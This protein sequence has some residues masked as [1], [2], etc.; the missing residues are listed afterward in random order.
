MK[1][2]R[3]MN[4]WGWGWAD[5]AEAEDPAAD[6]AMADI[7][8]KTYQSGE[9]KPLS[10]PKVEEFSLPQARIQPPRQLA[11]ICT[12]DAQDRIIHSLGKSFPDLA[13]A[14]Q[15]E[16]PHVTDMVAYPR[17]EQDVKDLLDWSGHQNV[18]LIPFGGGSSVCG[19]VEPAVGDK[20]EGVLS[21]DMRRLNK[22]L[23]ID[24][25]S[26][27]ARIEGGIFGPELEAGLKTHGYTLRHFPQSF[28]FSTL[29]GW[30]ATRSGGHYASLYTH[31]DDLVESM[32]TVTPAGVMESRRLPGSGAGPSPDR[33]MMGSEGILGVITQAWMR[34]QDRPVYKSSIPVLFENYYQAAE[35]VRALG[36]AWLFPTNCR[37]VDAQEAAGAVGGNHAMLILGFE[38]ADHP[39][40]AWMDRALELVADFGGLFDRSVLANKE[41]N[42]E[43]A[44]G[45]WRNAF[46]QAPYARSRAIA[47][48]LIVDTFESAVTWNRFEEFHQGICEG[49]NKVVREVTGHE[50]KVTCRFTHIYP[51][52]P[53]P[54]FTYSGLGTTSG[55]I[56]QWREIKAASLELV[57]SLGGTCTHHHA[58]GRDHR[59]GYEKQIPSLFQ[60]ALQAAKSALDPCGILNPG[61]L[62]DPLARKVGQQGSMSRV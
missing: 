41:S 30:I 15:R 62:I 29:G 11:E 40:E 20:Y 52:G 57:E 12:Q 58:V 8:A 33:M 54:Y 13:H 59:P 7:L 34:I 43:G 2:I 56:D 36:Q 10:R 18:A 61:V 27:A 46:M 16:I 9:I 1:D 28:E 53:A 44:A 60:E 51:D 38:S 17:H 42:K 19:G 23:E 26:R 32:T 5:D 39:V 31:I 22:V 14:A 25:V 6:K 21:L 3:R 35:A 37:L 45:Q 4:F 49:M 47:C 48:G 55:M 24:E 50:S